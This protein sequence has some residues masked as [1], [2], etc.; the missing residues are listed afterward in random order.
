LPAAASVVLLIV[1]LTSVTYLAMTLTPALGAG[2]AAQR[3]ARALGVGA[4]AAALAA[5]ALG[6]RVGAVGRG[7]ELVPTLAVG[8]AASAA[9]GAAAAFAA[10]GA[11]WAARALAA[12]QAARRA[13]LVGARGD[14]QARRLT[15]RRAFI[16]GEDLRAE[17]REAEASLARLGAALGELGATNAEVEERIGALD[18]SSTSDL[19]RELRRTHGEVATKLD[20]GRRIQS[21]AAEAA[22]RIACTVPVRLLLRRRP[23]DLARSIEAASQEGS[24]RAATAAA[25]AAGAA[26]IEVFLGEVET[27]RG[28]LAALESR[29]PR[30]DE[31]AEAFPEG[32]DGDDDGDGEDAWGQAMRDVAAIEEAYEAVR[33]RLDVVAMRFRARAGME[34]VASAAGEVSDKARASGIPAGDLQELVDEVTRAESAIVMATPPDLD[35]RSLTEALARGA[36]ALGGSDGASLDELLRALREV[37]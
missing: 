25:L 27:A 29:R 4:A 3:R 10:L 37:V 8:V 23:R 2:A 5:A 30:H 26:A 22:F 17:V 24:P 15:A 36:A 18:D 34:A 6:L 7:G 31:G 14:A 28:E 19:G 21:A 16:E 9:F 32:D 20:L 1:A 11:G 12:A 33:Q 35:A 13:A